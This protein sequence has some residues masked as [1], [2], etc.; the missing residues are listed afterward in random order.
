MRICCKQCRQVKFKFT[1]TKYCMSYKYIFYN[2]KQTLIHSRPQCFY[3]KKNKRCASFV[4]IEK[5]RDVK[6]NNVINNVDKSSLR[7]P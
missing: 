6:N 1:M 7:A 4:N 5:L 3:K 2:F